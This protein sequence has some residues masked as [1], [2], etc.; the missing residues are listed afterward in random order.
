MY[1]CLAFFFYLV[2]HLSI[3]LFFSSAIRLEHI[4]S[5]VLELFVRHTSLLRTIGEGG[6]LKLAADMAQVYAMLHFV[7][8][9]LV[10]LGNH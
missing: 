7:S 10:P 4:A 2:I 9:L 1:S 8:S 5:R 6:K 3:S